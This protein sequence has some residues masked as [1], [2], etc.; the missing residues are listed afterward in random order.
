MSEVLQGKNL[1]IKHRIV[2]YT[3]GRGL[4]LACGTVKTWPHFIG[5]D[6]LMDWHGRITHP[7][8]EPATRFALRV[9]VD[10]HADAFELSMFAGA[11]MDF[12]VASHIL[13]LAKRPKEAL[14]EWWR[15]IKQGGHL[16]IYGPCED[17]LDAQVMGFMAA[18]AGGFDF[19]EN[20]RCGQTDTFFQVYRK[21]S[22]RLQVMSFE[23]K[24]EKTAAVV[25]FGAYG[26]M[27]QATSILTGLK[28]Q[29][30]H[31]TMFTNPRGYEVV[32]H[33]PRV[34]RFLLQ[35]TDQV[36]TD[37]LGS[38]FAYWKTRFDKF[39]QLSESVEVSQL[40]MPKMVTAS[41]PNEARQL[42]YN[43][44]YLEITHA[45]AGVPLP[46]DPR[47]YPTAKEIAFASR[48]RQKIAGKVA[49]WVSDGSSVHKFWPYMDNAI[50]R[51]LS[52]SPD[53]HV[54]IV[55]GELGQLLESGWEN[56]PRVHR[57]C[58][59]WS[60]RESLTF[61]GNTDLVIGPET[62]VMNAVAMKEVPKII[63]LSHSGPQNLVKHWKNTIALQA[64]EGCTSCHLLIYGW[65][66]CRRVEKTIYC[67]DKAM[68][69]AGAECQVNIDVD[70]FWGAFMKAQNIQ[71]KAA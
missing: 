57:K 39:V 47:F 31:V 2:P 36:P 27:I 52:T 8:I 17:T 4:D 62:G 46:P 5:V 48:E 14:K 3:R 29:G 11:S 21:R 35:D 38:Y 61:A 7:E 26:D 59:K 56:E 70:D 20:E 9:S 33:D 69:I 32:Q 13:G 68:A 44:D 63:F 60:I 16:V 50:A 40:V 1:A 64:K 49:V 54:V 18:N 10:V 55:G 66:H 58:G 30:Y 6:N 28:N 67:G 65:A 41:W 45:I 71:K 24:P 42:I 15:V 43:A 19:V 25:R 53:W 22:D 37:E 23:K 34:D 51:I 12:V